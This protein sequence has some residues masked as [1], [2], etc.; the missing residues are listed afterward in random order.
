[1][2]TIAEKLTTIDT[3]LGNIKT[4][5]INKGQTPSGDITTYATAINN[6]SGG[7]GDELEV[8]N[9]TGST[10]NVGDKAWLSPLYLGSTPDVSQFGTGASAAFSPK[11]VS[12]DGTLVYDTTSGLLFNTATK[13]TSSASALYQMSQGYSGVVKYAD[14]GMIWA[15]R[16]GESINDVYYG[17][18]G[19]NSYG[20]P[21]TY[22]YVGGDYYYDMTNSQFV[23]MAAGTMN[24]IKT[25]T[26]NTSVGSFTYVALCG[27]SFC[28]TNGYIYYKS[29]NPRIWRAIVDDE[30]GTITDDALMLDNTSNTFVL[31]YVTGDGKY[32]L[33]YQA[34]VNSDSGNYFRIYTLVNNTLQEVGD[35]NEL[36]PD[37]LPFYNNEYT[38]CVYNQ[39]DDILVITNRSTRAIAVFKYAGDKFTKIAGYTDTNFSDARYWI[40][41]T[42]SADGSIIAYNTGAAGNNQTKVIQFAGNAEYKVV[43]YQNINIS[44]FSLTGYVTEGGVSGV[45]VKVATVMPEQINVNVTV[46][47]DNAII[48]GGIE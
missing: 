1:M 25:Y 2:T 46:N 23:K 16:N 45:T 35:I 43:N 20:V 36:S 12:R 33:S 26:D 47:A 31:P 29:S 42:A 38:T 22:A 8:L 37:L 19:G 24:V 39:Q 18:V 41:A 6:I 7:S 44:S 4:A 27:L 48:S 28:Y 9:L 5:I 32:F 11:V 15:Y 3:A 40:Y 34:S 17:S 14:N 21:T 13:T 10:L 30:A